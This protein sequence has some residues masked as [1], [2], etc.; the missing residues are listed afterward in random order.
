MRIGRGSVFFFLTRFLLFP[1][2]HLNPSL[3]LSVMCVVSWRELSRRALA[4]WLPVS[5]IYYDCRTRD[6]WMDLCARFW[7]LTFLPSFT[8]SLFFMLTS[9]AAGGSDF[10]VP[11]WCVFFEAHLPVHVLKHCL[12]HVLGRLS[13]PIIGA[14]PVFWKSWGLLQQHLESSLWWRLGGARCHRGVQTAGLWLPAQ[15]LQLESVRPQN[16]SDQPQLGLFRTW[17]VP[18]GVPKALRVWCPQLQQ[19]SGGCSYMFRCAFFCSYWLMFS[20]V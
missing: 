10:L 2:R 14:G 9:S 5:N 4:V 12:F 3:L 16:G 17:G 18:G 7:T 6:V 15:H 13:D 20:S 1:V 8:V 19:H 11:D